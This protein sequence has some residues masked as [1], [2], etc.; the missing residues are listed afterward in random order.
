MKNILR[1]HGGN[2]IENLPIALF[3]MR[4]LSNDTTGVSPF[5]M[6]T[7]SE[8]HIPAACFAS[9]Q[10]KNV[11]CV[12]FVKEL[13][14]HMESVQFTPTNANSQN[15]VYL[16][17][18]LQTCEK[19]WLRTD[20]VKKP[21]EAPYSGP[22]KVLQ[23][24][25]KTFKIEMPSGR[26]EAV[27]IDR[28]KPVIENFKLNGKPDAR[29][30]Q[31]VQ[32]SRMMKEDDE[33]GDDEEQEQTEEEELSN[34]EKFKSKIDYNSRYGRRVRFATENSIMYVAKEGR[35]IPVPKRW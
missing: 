11:D 29:R 23:K 25:E 31:L 5:S 21:L 14:K 27:S 8:A 6:V 22:Y 30:K 18:E 28:L 10:Q 17:N 35:S 20:R 3:A 12:K 9:H 2:W 34:V 15:K 16:P 33:D 1:Y 13:A 4:I 7:G 26:V 24:K 32:N 19:V